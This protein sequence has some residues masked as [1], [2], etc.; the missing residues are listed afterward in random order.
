MTASSAAGFIIFLLHPIRSALR[1]DSATCLDGF[2]FWLKVIL[3]N[4]L[5]A[6]F[7]SLWSLLLLLSPGVTAHYRYR[8]AIN[9]SSSIIPEVRPGLHP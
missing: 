4:I 3:L 7:I 9:M 1:P 2:G 6:V 5:E 8:Q